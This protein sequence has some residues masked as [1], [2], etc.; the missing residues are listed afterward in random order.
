MSF[1]AA[2]FAGVFAALR[3]G[4]F[5]GEGMQ[6]SEAELIRLS[7]GRGDRELVGVI[8]ARGDLMQ[9]HQITTPERISMFLAQMAHESG[10]F[11]VREENL[12]YSAKRM[13]EVWKKRFPTIG[14]A[15]PYANNPRKLAEKTYGGRKDLGNNQPG[16]GWKFR[17]RGA[18]QITGRDGYA[19]IGRIMGRLDIVDNPDLVA[20]DPA[21]WFETACAF[22]TWKKLNQWADARDLRKCTV[23]INGGYNGLADRE[24]NYRLACE[25]F[26]GAPAIINV[27]DTLEFGDVGPRVLALQEDLARLKYHSGKIDNKFGKLTRASVLAFQAEHGLVVDGRAG[28]KTL[29]AIETAE[30]RDL[31]EREEITAEDLKEAGS[32]TVS[33]ADLMQKASVGA[34]AAAS[35]LTLA[36]KSGAMAWMTTASEQAT[37]FNALFGALGQGVNLLMNNAALLIIAVGVGGFF[38]ARA[39]KNA[40]VEDARSGANLRR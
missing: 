16:D 7:Q 34:A 25:L 28:R 39:V 19:N 23:R 6:I 1:R 24:A 40:R 31:G 15:R 36:E 8:A 13:T 12:N 2:K 33:N 14:S 37:S 3:G 35:G 4:F 32:T 21:L 17:G 20:S 27:D 9:K 5:M 11:S 26:T 29:A 18:I 30:P 22:W 10:G 38:I